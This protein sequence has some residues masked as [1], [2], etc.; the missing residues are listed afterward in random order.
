MTF[1]MRFQFDGEFDEAQFKRAYF[2]VIKDHSLLSSRVEGVATGRRSGLHWNNVP[3][4][5][6]SLVFLTSNDMSDDWTERIDLHQS[7]GLRIY[8]TRT[9]NRSSILAQ[10]HHACSDAIGIIDFL[11]ALLKTY[12]MGEAHKPA[13]NTDLIKQRGNLILKSGSL[14]GHLQKSFERVRRFATFKPEPLASASIESPQPKILPTLYNTFSEET[15]LAIVEKAKFLNATVNDLLVRDFFL[16]LDLWNRVHD[17]RR[18]L[19]IA[20]PVNL[21]QAQHQHMP[22]ANI[23]SLVFLDRSEGELDN[24]DT[25]LDSIVRETTRIK[26]NQLALTMPRLARTLGAIPHGIQR[27]TGS[28]NCST[29]RTTAVLS[30][31]G[32]ISPPNEIEGGYPQLK[33]IELYPPMRP[34]THISVGICTFA[35]KLTVSVNFNRQAFTHD[36]AQKLLDSFVKRIQSTSVI[37]AFGNKL[38]RSIAVDK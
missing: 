38:E 5:E 3:P 1:F 27:L 15:T 31:L 24:S 2:A 33:A 11:D 4:D 18:L 36:M 17:Q 34:E 14:I 28:P 37:P 10:I 30:N 6:S 20:I 22:A 32:K 25:L 19:R 12:A 35:A 8:V 21:R 13:T 9:E 29:C 7:T 16:E 26:Q 23:V